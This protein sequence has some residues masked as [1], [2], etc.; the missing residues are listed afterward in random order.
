VRTENFSGPGAEINSQFKT[1]TLSCEKIM[2]DIVCTARR[3]GDRMHPAGRGVGKSLKSLFLEAGLSRAERDEAL[4]FRDSEGVLAVWP[5]AL[6]ERVSP[7]H[8]G[9][10]MR[11]TVEPIE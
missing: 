11:L 4:V 3:P 5:L 2:G 8:G 1:F 10:L 9:Q 6:D 7:A